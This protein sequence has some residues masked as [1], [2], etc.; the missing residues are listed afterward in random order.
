MKLFLSLIFS[1]FILTACTIGSDTS[2]AS[3]SSE[4]SPYPSTP[5]SASGTAASPALTTTG[6]K[7]YLANGTEPFW[8]AEVRRNR[9]TF[10][11]P[12]ESQVSTQTFDVMQEDK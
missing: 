4:G 10:S 12:G 7:D 1:C 6:G 11:R 9:L 8:S 3:R 5:L 2:R